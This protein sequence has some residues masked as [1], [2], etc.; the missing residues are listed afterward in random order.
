MKR[1]A[2]ILA[3]ATA[4]PALAQPA[5]QPTPSQVMVGQLAQALAQA[6]DQEAALREQLAAIQKPGQSTPPVGTTAPA[7]AVTPPAPTTAAAP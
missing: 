3:I 4:T 7:T 2:F 5:K 1:L 6:Q